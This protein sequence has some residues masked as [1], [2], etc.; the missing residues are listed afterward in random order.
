[1]IEVLFAEPTILYQMDTLN[2]AIIMMC[3]TR[4]EGRIMSV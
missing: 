4:N 1:M 3:N 2:S